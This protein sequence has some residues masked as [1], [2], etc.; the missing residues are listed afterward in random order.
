[1]KEEIVNAEAVGKKLA[2]LI[3]ALDIPDGSKELIV[4]SL[5]AMSLEQIDRLVIV[6]EAKFSDA[7]T[8]LIDELHKQ[9]LSALAEELDASIS[10]NEDVLAKNLELLKDSII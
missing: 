5:P 4:S 6:L 8:S 3:A 10:A 1:M 2:Y 7:T 9:K